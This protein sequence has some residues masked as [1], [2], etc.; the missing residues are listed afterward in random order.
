MRALLLLLPLL[1]LSACNI[2]SDPATN[3]AYAIEAEVDRLGQDEGASYTIEYAPPS[4]WVERSG[5]YTV[6]F[7]KVGALIVWYK[8]AGGK[9]TASGSTS[10]IA[11]FVDV[12][13]TYIVNKPTDS[14]LS[15]ELHRQNGRAVVTNV[16]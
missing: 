3:L 2:L 16:Q 9:V 7:D 14:V 12:P 8:D 11:R 5:T 4:R 15:I 1:A 6:Q 13:R 10:Y